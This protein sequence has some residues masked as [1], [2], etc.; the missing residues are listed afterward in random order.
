M[1]TW[2]WTYHSFR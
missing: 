1:F 2:I